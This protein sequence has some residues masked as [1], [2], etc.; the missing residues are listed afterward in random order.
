MR[1]SALTLTALLAAA[2]AAADPVVVRH[3]RPRFTL[4]VPDGF[5]RVDP[6]GARGDLLDVFRRPGDLPDEPPMVLEVLHL[7]AIV[8]QRALLPA[9]RAELRRAD[10]F[11][12]VDHVEHD[13][14]LGFPVETL[15]GT[16]TMPGDI[17]VTRLATA[18]P[19]EDDSVLVVLQAPGHRAREARAVLRA[20]LSSVRGPTT[21]ETPARRA[22]NHAMRMVS[23]VTLLAS[24]AYGVAAAIA[25]RRSPL[26]PRSRLLA[27]GSLAVLWWAASIWLCVPWREHERLV[28]AQALGCAVMFSALAWRARQATGSS[29]APDPGR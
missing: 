9:E 10:A 16:S 2:S 14:V 6:D 1:P 11:P 22:L 15:V 12:F 29:S 21:W 3:E 4:T 18:I 13:R 28:A 19:L 5:E 17:S 7:D 23:L 26:R 27:T 8:P 25:A 24:L 20:T